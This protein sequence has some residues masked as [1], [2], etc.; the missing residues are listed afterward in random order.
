MLGIIV[1]Y[2]ICVPC[3]ELCHAVGLLESLRRR[4]RVT[5]SSQNRGCDDSPSLLP[6]HARW[7]DI[8]V[9]QARS[10]LAV[11]GALCSLDGKKAET[12]GTPFALSQ[13]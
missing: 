13:A 7:I 6:H 3:T 5:R 2:L 8:V 12:L 10:P 1:P 11:S 4:T 9:V